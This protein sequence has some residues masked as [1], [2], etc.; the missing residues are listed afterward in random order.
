MSKTAIAGN[1]IKIIQFRPDK[2]I[3]IRLDIWSVLPSKLKHQGITFQHWVQER[4]CDFDYNSGVIWELDFPQKASKIKCFRVQEGQVHEWKIV[5]YYRHTL[6]RRHAA[7][8]ILEWGKTGTV[9]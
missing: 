6:W 3:K 5:P 8:G 4:V 7:V 2:T 1:A 9:W